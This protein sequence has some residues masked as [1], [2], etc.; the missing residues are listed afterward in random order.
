MTFPGSLALAAS[1]LTPA[2][3]SIAYADRVGPSSFAGKEWLVALNLGSATALFLIALLFAGDLVGHLWRNRKRDRFDH[4]VTTFRVILLLLTSG[5][6]MR[7]GAAAA[8][9]WKW[10]PDDP[11]GTNVALVLQRFVD[12]IADTVQFLAL[13]L[14]IMSA[15]T[16]VNQLRRTPWHI[17][18][19]QSLPLLSRPA[20]LAV[21][22]FVAAAGVVLTR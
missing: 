6:V 11:V 18:I 7:K 15:R 12:P 19:W 2:Q 1:A 14:A 8:V 20:I 10:S 16:L 21:M 9:L 3:L 4:P 17:P 5:I 13:A 22:S